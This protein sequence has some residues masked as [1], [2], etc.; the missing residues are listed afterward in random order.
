MLTF[1]FKVVGT[2]L[3][4]IT[5][6]VNKDVQAIQN[7][8]SEIGNK[9]KSVMISN[10]NSGIKRKSSGQL[11]S[12]MNME[13]LPGLDTIFVGVGKIS[14][15]NSKVPYW[16]V[17]NYGARFPGNMDSALAGKTG[18]PYVPPITRGSFASTPTNPD[19]SLSDAQR[20][21]V[22]NTRKNG[23]FYMV[24]K[25]PIRPSNYIEKTRS[26]LTNYWD[27]F[28]SSV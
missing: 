24:P 23:K 6:T 13:L 11:S 26:W 3:S 28:W 7:K 12:V 25:K 19:G 21:Q 20:N 16:F 4:E 14:D 9:T 22:W 10:I 18:A 1:T 2:P 17:V 27:I 5:R 8:M 15:L